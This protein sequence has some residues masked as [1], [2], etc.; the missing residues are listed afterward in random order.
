MKQQISIGFKHCWQQILLP[1]GVCLVL[2]ACFLLPSCKQKN[3]RKR[4]L[5]MG[6]MPL[7]E[8]PFICFSEAFNAEFPEDEY[9]LLFY[10]GT[11]AAYDRVL[12]PSYYDDMDAFMRLQFGRVGMRPDLIIL[13]GD[14]VAHSAAMSSHPWYDE[15]PV[16]CMGVMYPEWGGALQ[17]RKNFVVM[18]SACDPKKNMDFIRELGGAPWIITCID[19]TFLDEKIRS[20][21]MEEMGSDTA[22]YIT[23]LQLESYDRLIG[24][25]MR[26]IRTTI[27]PINFEHANCTPADSM[28]N[29][30]FRIPGLMKVRNNWATFLRLKDD[31]YIGESFGYN[32]GP[33]YSN[34]CKYFNLPLLSALNGNIGGYFSNWDEMADQ[35]HP[36]V[37]QLLSGD[38][39][40]TIPQQELQKSYWL[41][42]RLA[43]AMHPYAEDF[44]DYVKFTNL[45]WEEKSR[46]NHIVS[47]FWLPFIFYLLLF[48]AL[49]TPVV[50]TIISR[51]QHKKL[52]RLGA[53]AAQDSQHMETVLAATH[54][55]RWVLLPN[56]VIRLSKDLVRTLQLGQDE[57]PLSELLTY[58]E[59]GAKELEDA[60]LHSEED[61][62]TVD[63]VA[64]TKNGE[65]HAFMV[66][67]N[68]LLDANGQKQCL[69]FIVINDEVY[70]AQKL[71][72]EAY[73]LA[74]ETTVK[75]SFMASMSHEIR[76]P[77]NAIV[78]FADLLVKHGKDLSQE[79]RSAF[80]HHINDSKDQ[81]LRLLDDVMNYSTKKE[82]SFSLELSKK[83]VKEL[84]DE[85]YYMH[86]VIVPERL[87]FHYECS[88]DAFVMANRS[89]V[90]QIMS[91][92][93]NNAIKFTEAGSITMGWRY[94]EEADGSWVEMYVRDTGIG[95][96]ETDMQH[97]CEKFRKVDSH[98]VGAG[99]G[100]ALC[101][102]LAASMKGALCMDSKLGEGS[103]FSLKLKVTEF[104]PPPAGVIT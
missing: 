67:I 10:P 8:Q 37:D 83:S 32:L 18:T 40:T 30:H 66:Y 81:L 4:I 74:E 91:N 3:E 53:K 56:Q 19:S 35:A 50:L 86:T 89:A 15:V 60:L 7:S 100:L 48:L 46:L 51:H 61:F 64:T 59:D 71:R 25:T 22:H 20:S 90:L 29:G 21:I 52:L 28:Y 75:E 85:A 99:I 43:K 54:S 5:L 31:A 79:E 103:T 72:Q 55:F 34:S 44:P 92:L 39:P 16:L 98:S 27:I 11:T 57:M 84:M 96:S 14:M 17:Q 26:D 95:I 45:P 97:I 70:E 80:S 12:R 104:P 68:R 82:E 63:I 41:D 6:D 73:Q 13:M 76:S 62:Q 94:T 33:F 24:Y 69:G 78:G 77:L 23:N 58:V 102:Q 87:D 42:W 88:K 49:M 9:E 93:M 101:T 2:C 1:M 47:R 36:I 65:R 38:D